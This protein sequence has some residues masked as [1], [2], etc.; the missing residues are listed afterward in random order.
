MALPDSI[1]VMAS[2]QADA[3]A[4]NPDAVGDVLA[5]AA[6]IDLDAV[7]DALVK[8]ADADVEPTETSWPNLPP[9][10]LR[11]SESA[12][13][14]HNPGFGSH[15]WCLGRGRRRRD[16]WWSFSRRRRGPGRHRRRHGLC[17]RDKS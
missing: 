12:C 9:L 2:N 4:T 1:S 10:T 3:A 7:G 5:D 13:F 11:P 16:S 6:A 8:A 15:K 17:H 14:C